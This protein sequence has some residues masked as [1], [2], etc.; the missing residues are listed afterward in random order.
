MVPFFNGLGNA[1]PVHPG[2]GRCTLR[3]RG[4]VATDDI[5]G[6]HNIRA[7]VKARR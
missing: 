6:P 3:E 5:V 2:V 4:A 1:S 7:D